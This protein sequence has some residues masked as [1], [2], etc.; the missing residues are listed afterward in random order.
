MVHWENLMEDVLILSLLAQEKLHVHLVEF[1]EQVVLSM[2][3][4]PFQ[5]SEGTM[6]HFPDHL[7]Y[8]QANLLKQKEYHEKI[9]PEDNQYLLLSGQMREKILAISPEDRT[10]LLTNLLKEEQV[11]KSINGTLEMLPAEREQIVRQD[12]LQEEREEEHLLQKI[13]P[14]L[15]MMRE[16]EE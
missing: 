16:T 1:R 10:D 2:F 12:L 7:L 15:P 13:H 3:V 9:K 8:L 5:L 11:E 4:A 14:L 6:L